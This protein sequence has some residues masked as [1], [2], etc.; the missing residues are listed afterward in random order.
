M[1]DVPQEMR[2]VLQG[3]A[4]GTAVEQLQMAQQALAQIRESVLITGTHLEEPGP[5]IVYVNAAFTKMTGWLPEEVVGR[6]PRFL[7]GPKT[8]RQTLDRLR[9]QLT[10]GESFE[11][12][13][14][15]YRKDGSEFFI[16][17]Y[18]EPLRGPA[19]EITYWVAVQRDVTE[20][21]LLQAQLLQAQRLEGIGLLASGIAHDLNNVLTPV[22]MGCEFLREHVTDSEAHEF[23]QLVE[24]SGRRGAALVRQILSFGR[25]LSG[26]SGLVEPRH[27]INEVAHMAQATFPKAITVRDE[28]P[29]SLWSVAADPSQL[30]QVV[31]N[32]CINARDAIEGAGSI[33]LTACNLV[34]ESAPV[35][36]RG[37]LE[38]GDHIQISVTDTGSGMPETVAA[39][40]FEPFY[41]TKSADKGTG[42]GLSTVALIVQNLK[43][44]IDLQ[45][46]PG[47]GTTFS[48]YLPATNMTAPKTAEALPARARQ[49]GG[50]TVLI[51]D[52]EAAVSTIM[53]EVLQSANYRAHQASNGLAALTAAERLRPDLVLL[54]LDMPGA[55]GRDIF[56]QF[57][58][59][60]PELPIVLLSG[61]SA[62]EMEEKAPGATGMLGKPFT[63]AQLLGAVHDALPAA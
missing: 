37:S 57:R 3:V 60:F 15:N 45:T 59:R 36:A 29:L 47:Q 22:L 18:I 2:D 8:T 56:Q 25:G 24:D 21:R 23:I 20:K 31:L 6:S 44:A 49:G 12:E 63:P 1:P 19:G 40:I 54:D 7:Q 46:A 33:T 38:P 28:V 14:V 51:A 52:D 32:L 13:D 61:Y 42:L 39:K 53:C 43:G 4:G 5:E 55:V 26:A 48:I 10:K 50:R 9:R 11:G 58:Q 17:W 16:D 30:H 27:I 34:L 62:P 41:S 35:T